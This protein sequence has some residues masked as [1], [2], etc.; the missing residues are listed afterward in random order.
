M[1]KYIVFKHIGRFRRQYFGMHF[2]N[3]NI[4][5]TGPYMQH[6][7][8]HVLLKPDLVPTFVA[9]WPVSGQS[10]LSAI[11]TNTDIWLKLVVAVSV[12]GYS[13]Y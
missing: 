6:I 7:N 4:Y 12:I 2:L 8:Y 3:E 5:L 1:F 10:S 9:L 13:R 11:I